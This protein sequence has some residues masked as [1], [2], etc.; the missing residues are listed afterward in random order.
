LSNV[1]Y[2]VAH[3]RVGSEASLTNL[4]SS[5]SLPSLR[6]RLNTSPSSG[7]QSRSPAKRFGLL[8]R[9]L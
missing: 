2:R 3:G 5:V 6:T 7:F 1:D 4:T 8:H 9:L